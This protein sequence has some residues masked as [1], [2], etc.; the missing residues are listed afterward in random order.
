MVKKGPLVQKFE[1]DDVN[2][3]HKDYFKDQLWGLPDLD[4]SEKLYLISRQYFESR[5]IPITDYTVDGKLEI[6]NKGRIQDLLN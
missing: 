4:G 6:F 1:G 2:H 3:F 5:N